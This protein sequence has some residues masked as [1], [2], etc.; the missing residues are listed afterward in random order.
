[1]QDNVINAFTEQ[2]Q[3]MFAPISKFN[4]LMVESLEKMT[5]F[6]LGAVKSYSEIFL[7]QVKKESEVK[8]VETLR[9]F[10][11]SQAEAAGSINKK[12]I[13]DAKMLSDMAA[14]FKGQVEAIMEESRTTA[15]SAA[16]SKPATKKA[17]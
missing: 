17:S 2:A 3:S 8:D 11:T 10:S 5:E 13:E 7:G 16:A 9:T 4:G 15:T 14:D 12:I 6:Q 1:M